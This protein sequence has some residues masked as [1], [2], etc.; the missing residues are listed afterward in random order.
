MKSILLAEDDKNFGTVLKSEIGDDEY[1]VTLVKDGVEAVLSFLSHAYD[2]VLL[3]IQMPRLNGIDALRIIKKIN[4]W[5]PALT[6]SGDAGS[7]EREESVRAGSINCLAKPF[8]I[9][10][11][12]DSIKDCIQGQGQQ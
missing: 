3:D 1:T 11:L 10:Q 5:V 8:D 12:K 6:F 9:G 4:P 2:F 7:Q